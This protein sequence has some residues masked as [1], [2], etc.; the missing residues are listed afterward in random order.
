MYFF[1]FDGYN[2][3]AEREKIAERERGTMKYVALPN[4]IPMPLLGY[5]TLQISAADC[6]RCV[7]AAVIS[8]RRDGSLLA[9]ETKEYTT[10]I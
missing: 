5:G 4:G 10:I 9:E 1:G 8:G 7:A 6:E 3:I 2:T